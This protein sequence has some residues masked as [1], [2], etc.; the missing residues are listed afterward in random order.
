[1]V[2]D[3]EEP[4]QIKLDASE[5]HARRLNAKEVLLPKQGDEFIFPRAD[6][7]VKLAGQ[8]QVFRIST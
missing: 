3:V 7:T 2:A 8:D 5:I 1:M 6:G 4:K